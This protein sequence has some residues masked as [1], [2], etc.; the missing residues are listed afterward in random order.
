[1]KISFYF[2]DSYRIGQLLVQN[3]NG[4]GNRVR[5]MRLAFSRYFLI[6]LFAL[7][8]IKL[9]LTDYLPGNSRIIRKTVQLY[10][11]L[12]W[13]ICIKR[14]FYR[15]TFIELEYWMKSSK[16]KYSIFRLLLHL[17]K[18]S[19]THWIGSLQSCPLN[20]LSKTLETLHEVSD[21]FR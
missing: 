6:S 3:L 16:K 20:N 8:Q 4:Q 10:V 9:I 11:L 18:R 15:S 1:M 5:S 19:S 2:Q 21:S 17:W 13:W 14:N 7:V 12:T